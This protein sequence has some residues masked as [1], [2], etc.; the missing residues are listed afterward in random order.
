MKY[1]HTGIPTTIP[2][3]DEVYLEKYDLHCTDHESNS[4]G[5]QWMRYGTNCTLPKV[6]QE[7]AHVAFQVEDIT[8]ALKGK[9]VLIEPNSP[10]EGVIVAFIIENG[11]PIEFLQYL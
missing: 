11:A 6:V 7:V 4:F 9:E 8:E 5:I 10:S 3:K 2:Q 1:H